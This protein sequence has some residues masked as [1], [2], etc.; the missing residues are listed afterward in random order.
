MIP[1]K[2]KADNFANLSSHPWKPEKSQVL[3]AEQLLLSHTTH[4][5]T[6]P[7]F[8]SCFNFESTIKVG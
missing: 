6:N 4:V 2:Q 8:A 5:T 1:T 7:I 3:D